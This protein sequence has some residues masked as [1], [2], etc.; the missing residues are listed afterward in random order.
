MSEERSLYEEREHAEPIES[1]KLHFDTIF[2]F[3][4]ENDRVPTVPE[5]MEITKLSYHYAAHIRRRALREFPKLDIDEIG[6]AVRK[7]LM[8]RLQ[9][10]D[11]E[12]SN[13]VKLMPWVAPQM[14]SAVDVKQEI[15]HRFIVVKPGDEK[16][17][18][19]KAED[20]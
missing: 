4:I 3:M 17:A 7:L 11:V 9:S 13:L 14:A 6:F 18:E 5:T 19:E 16:P 12:T 10:G 8:E 20:N 2:K 1:T 15:T